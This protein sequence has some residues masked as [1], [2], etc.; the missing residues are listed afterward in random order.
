MSAGTSL[1]TTVELELRNYLQEALYDSE[2]KLR[3]IVENSI[4]GFVMI[5][6]DGFVVMWNPGQERITGVSASAALGTQLCDVIWS[7]TPVHCRN[8]VYHDRLRQRLQNAL[9]LGD[10]DSFARAFEL[11]IERPSGE[12]RIVQQFAFAMA[13]GAG[14]RLGCIFHDVTEFRQT[15]VN[16]L[17]RNTELN[18]L[19]RIN[20][21][22]ASSVDLEQV[23]KTILKEVLELLQ[24]TTASIWLKDDITGALVCA[25]SMD[26][27]GR[28]ASALAVAQWRSLAESVI[29]NGQPLVEHALIADVLAI[30]ASNGDRAYDAQA[31][32]CVPIKFRDRILGVLLLLHEHPQLIREAEIHVLESI[33][34]AAG[35]AFENVSL[36]QNAQELVVLQERQRLA[37]SLHDAINQSLFSAGLI[38]DSLP[39]LIEREPAQAASSLQ[40][41]R[42]LLR[43]AVADLRSVLVELQPALISRADFGDLLSTLAAGYTGRTSTTVAVKVGAKVSFSPRTQETLYRI[44]REAI[45][46]IAKH[47]DAT[48]VWVELMRRRSGVQIYIRDNGRG[49]DLDHIPSGHFGLMMM[50]QQA[51]DVGAEF[52]VV[53]KVGHGTEISIFIPDSKACV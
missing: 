11:E 52:L 12:V 34:A 51:V 44:C 32:V 5:D 7:L 2:S 47:A 25:Q 29:R 37:I 10:G 22:I 8:E 41:L 23:R 13:P 26:R 17:R 14:P 20:S 27:S 4:D 3:N 49:M 6:A 15:A 18:L 40:D 50:E 43:G 53:S 19:N 31:V 21:V 35:A 46:N 1:F 30:G 45:S 9:E 16:L 36:Y 38:A 28:P 42:L 24:V 39:R 33:A 48:Q